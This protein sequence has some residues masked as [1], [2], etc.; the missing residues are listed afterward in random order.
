MP[1]L[2][3]ILYYFLFPVILI[4]MAVRYLYETY[5]L[6]QMVQQDEKRRDEEKVEDAKIKQAH[7]A[8]VAARTEWEQFRAGLTTSDLHHEVREGATGSGQGDSGTKPVSGK[9]S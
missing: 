4:S 8:S 2:K 9:Q 6:G 1:L 5:R 7:D 3:K